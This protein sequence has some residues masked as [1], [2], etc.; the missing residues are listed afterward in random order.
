MKNKFQLQ[1]DASLS[2]LCYFCAFFCA[3]IIFIC[4]L[5]S[6]CIILAPVAG[7]LGLLYNVG[8]YISV[9]TAYEH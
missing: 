1:A 6:H 4:M 8:N 9:L 2:F 3:I 7:F 5:R